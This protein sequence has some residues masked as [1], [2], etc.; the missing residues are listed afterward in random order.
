[1]IKR[2]EILSP[3]LQARIA[4]LLYLVIFIAA[5][6]GAAS[7]TPVN[8]LITLSCDIGVALLLYRL[9]KPVNAKLSLLAAIFRLLL[10]VIMAVNAANFFGL[11]DLFASAHS[12]KAFN[13]LYGISLAPFGMHCALAGYLIFKSGFLPRAVGIL[14]A[15][16]GGAYLFFLWPPLGDQLFFPYLVIPGVIGEG[17]L[18]L[19]LIV[20]GVNAERW[21]AR[22]QP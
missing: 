2:T 19:W 1:M 18:T 8:M 17:S 7:A 13:R 11:I 15:L 21:A 14:F 4:G 10:V 5:P 16:A 9:L 6:S 12:V 3:R 22:A 20:F